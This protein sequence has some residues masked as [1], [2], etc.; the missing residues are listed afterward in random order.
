MEQ[1]YIY[2]ITNKINGKF[3]IGKHKQRNHE[4]FNFYYGSGKIINAAIEKY[5]KQ[6]FYK[7]ILEICTQE[8]IDDREVYWINKLNAIKYGYNISIGGAGGNSTNNTKVYTNGKHRKYL[9]LGDKI[10]QGFYKGV[11]QY[12][13]RQKIN[14][15]N[16]MKGV[17]KGK[18]PWN[19]GK[20]KNNEIVKLNSQNA[21]N[22]IKRTG[23]L[24]GANNPHAKTYIFIDPNNNQYKVTGES[25][26]F[27]EK[28]EI[29]LGLLL[30]FLD[31][32]KVFIRKHNTS[33]RQIILNTVGWQMLSVNCNSIEQAKQARKNTYKIC[34]E[35]GL[36]SK[37]Q[38]NIN[39][40]KTIKKDKENDRN[41]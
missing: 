6:N 39:N 34:F 4:D 22:T 2:K 28:H 5:G 9:K 29:S 21:S 40:L 1:F 3:Y 14:M 31:K 13:I 30:S 35:K 20:N 38:M 17:N 18:I 16:S 10:P 15:S 32:G 26:I 27:C 24:K 36:L 8:N 11:Q 23:I 37:R 41:S 12:S 33:R 19:K 25:K 7:E